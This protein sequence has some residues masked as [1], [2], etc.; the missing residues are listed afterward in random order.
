[1]KAS[2]NRV[3]VLVGA[4]LLLGLAAAAPAAGDLTKDQVKAKLEAAGYTNVSGIRREKN[5]YDAKGTKDGKTVAVDVDAK[6]GAITPESE[7]SEATEREE[8][9]EK[10]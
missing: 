5:H 10:K 7:E 4:G 6:T 9:H 8:H 2:I 1:M 3:V